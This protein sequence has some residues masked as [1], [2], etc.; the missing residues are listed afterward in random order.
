MFVGSRS[1][2]LKFRC[3]LTVAKKVQSEKIKRYLVT[4]LTNIPI[5]S[6]EILFHFGYEVN[7]IIT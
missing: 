5:I 4:R 3:D 2:N 1:L 7:V 6:V